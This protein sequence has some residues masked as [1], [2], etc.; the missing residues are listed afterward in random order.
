[1]LPNTISSQS[2]KDW[3]KYATLHKCQSCRVAAATQELE[4]DGYEWI[5]YIRWM[6]MPNKTPPMDISSERLILTLDISPSKQS[7]KPPLQLLIINNTVIEGYCIVGARK[8]VGPMP[9]SA[10]KSETLLTS[11]PKEWNL[12]PLKNNSG[13]GGVGPPLQHNAIL[14][15]K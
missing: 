1:M 5:C 6:K 3:L 9:R 2:W 14:E 12:P 7:A 11:L 13:N 8:W 10:I 4:L 15:Q